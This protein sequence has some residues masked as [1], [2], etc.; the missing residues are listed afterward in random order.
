MSTPSLKTVSSHRSQATAPRSESAVV[1][2]PIL[3]A[4]SADKTVA[5]DTA[6]EKAESV[7]SDSPV[8]SSSGVFVPA[9]PKFS[10]EKSF[11]SILSTVELMRKL[12]K[13]AD[14]DGIYSLSQVFSTCLRTIIHSMDDLPHDIR[15]NPAYEVA[16]YGVVLTCNLLR[17]EVAKQAKA[18]HPANVAMALNLVDITISGLRSFLKVAERILAEN[19]PLPALPSDTTP[20]SVNENPGPLINVV[21]EVLNTEETEFESSSSL[22][23]DLVLVDASDIPPEKKKKNC[24]GSMIRRII[25]RKSTSSKVSIFT[26][27]T[28]SSITLV[29]HESV[30][31]STSPKE[32]FMVEVKE[33]APEIPYLP[34]QSAIYYLADPYCP[35]IDVE[36]PLPTGD[37]IAVRL[38]QHGVMKAASLTALVRILTS[39]DS[40]LDQ[41]FTPTFFIC[42]RFFTTPTRFLQE[43]VDRFDE[44]PPENLSSAQLRIWTRDAMG[45]HIRVGKTI[46]MWLDLYWKPETDSEVLD[47]LQMFTLERLVRE[48]PEGMVT[49][50]LE[51]LDLIWGDNPICRRTRKASDLEF[52][53]NRTITDPIAQTTFDISIDSS[54]D[55][56]AQL[57]LFSTP[58]GREELARQLTVRL[59][60][61]F[62]LVDPEDAIKYWH[63]N[64]DSEVGRILQAIISFERALCSWV[65]HSVL[66]RSAAEERR[67]MLEFWLDISAVSFPPSRKNISFL[68]DLHPFSA[69]S[70]FA[71]F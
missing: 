10:L 28:K 19:K 67:E 44:Q 55:P 51:G 48:L 68:K 25:G 37:T 18:N 32:S 43:L 56:I 26:H 58:A 14:T 8:P 63:L 60:E 41:E 52:I 54:L 38:D 62:Q 59:S 23:D 22:L 30:P 50:I 64:E 21:D 6:T 20:N 42:F 15:L 29:D 12:K 69:L 1:T 47:T 39:K 7:D 13:S 5:L 24:R 2:V 4:R 17:A 34:R 40:V 27:Q 16:Q 45:V 66:A 31:L 33:H 46:L 71:Q 49:H 3:P 65:T 11:P 70:A 9:I 61:Q 35:E 53:Y 36:M 57:L